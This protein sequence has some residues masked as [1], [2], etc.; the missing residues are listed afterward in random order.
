MSLY[1]VYSSPKT[2][3]SK[4]IFGDFIRHVV[5]TRIEQTR[6]AMGKPEAPAA[7]I[8][9][10]H[11]SHLTGK[12]AEILADRG[13]TLIFIPP[14]RCIFCNHLINCSLRT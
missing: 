2:F 5:I 11:K 1:R 7:I 13:I 9:D 10:G 14:I 12:I 4:K 3:V 6:K 8:M